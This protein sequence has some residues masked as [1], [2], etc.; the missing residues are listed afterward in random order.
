MNEESLH[1]VLVFMPAGAMLEVGAVLEVGVSAASKTDAVEHVAGE[2]PCADDVIWVME[3][4]D[5]E[6]LEA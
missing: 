1:V 2:F 6:C 5:H 4:E 3:K